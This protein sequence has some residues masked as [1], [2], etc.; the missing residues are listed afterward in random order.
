MQAIAAT[1]LALAGALPWSASPKDAPKAELVLKDSEG[2]RVRLSDFRGKVIVLN[3]WATWCGPCNVEMPMLMEAEKEYG[4]RG[5]VFVGASLDD[6][7]TRSRIPAFIDRYHI[8]F[9]V[10]VGASAEDL[11]KLGLGPA[12][13]ATAFLDPEGHIVA[14][15]LGEFREE[16]VRERVE[17]LLGPKTT[18]PPDPVVKHLE[19]K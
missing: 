2:K 12:V 3:F 16:E 19:E 4:P 1:A 11:D 15:I 6:A 8:D 17:W 7:K 13:P 5:V 9:P 18:P 14:R 10:W